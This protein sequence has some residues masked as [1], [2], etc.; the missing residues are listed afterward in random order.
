MR[1]TTDEDLV[2]A[3]EDA[4]DPRRRTRSWSFA[5]RQGRAPSD[6]ALLRSLDPAAGAPAHPP[7][8]RTAPA[9]RIGSDASSSKDG[10]PRRPTVGRLGENTLLELI[11]SLERLPFLA[12]E[13]SLLCALRVNHRAGFVLSQVDG[14][15]NVQM[16]LDVS[17][18]RKLETL[19][20]LYQLIEQ[21]II[22]TRDA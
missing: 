21:G 6:N 7:E 11:G 15:S 10:A 2:P 13:P 20:I 9:G 14:A 18:M 17:P 8:G 16:I 22:D 5:A 1:R 12:I 19:R 4:R 3:G